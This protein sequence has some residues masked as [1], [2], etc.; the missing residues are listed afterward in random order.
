M[1]ARPRHCAL[2]NQAIFSNALTGVQILYISWEFTAA[3][4]TGFPGVDR[5]PT[6]CPIMCAHSAPSQ[7]AL[8]GSLRV[9]HQAVTNTRAWTAPHLEINVHNFVVKMAF[10]PLL[11]ASCLSGSVLVL[12]LVLLLFYVVLFRT[13]VQW[14]CIMTDHSCSRSAASR[15]RNIAVRGW[16]R[17]PAW[18]LDW[19]RLHERRRSVRGQNGLGWIHLTYG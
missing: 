12:V 11:C 17:A 13:I 5:I 19:G 8:Q 15:R 1:S 9:G 2:T 7:M 16:A 10:P 4:S 18:D 14:F 3:G 6:R